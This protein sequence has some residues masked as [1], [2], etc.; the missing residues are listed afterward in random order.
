MTAR[1][2]CMNRPSIL[3][4]AGAMPALPV[5]CAI[6]RAYASCSSR[7]AGPR[8]RPACLKMAVLKAITATLLYMGKP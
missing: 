2:C 1:P 3:D 5:R 7:L 6:W 4:K 8:V